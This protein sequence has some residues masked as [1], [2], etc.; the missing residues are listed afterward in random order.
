MRK[1][2]LLAAAAGLAVAGST[3]KADFVMSIG[4]GT[5]L[6]FN[7]QALVAYPITIVNNGMGNTAGTTKFLG[8]DLTL[9]AYAPGTLRTGSTLPNANGSLVIHAFDQTPGDGTAPPDDADFSGT[10]GQTPLLSYVRFGTNTQIPQWTLVSTTPALNS[11]DDAAA[12]APTPTNPTPYQDGQ[13]LHQFE[14][15][16]AFNLAGNG[17][18]DTTAH[19]IALAVVPVGDSIS[20]SGFAGAES[21][22]QVATEVDNLVP[23]PA[24]LGLLGVGL[25][26]LVMRRR[27]A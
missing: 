27:R 11:P 12:I 25:G 26:A 9:A 6:T 24:S 4:T 7:G 13:S 20:A 23:E 19:L 22:P 16:G 15:V 2:A 18:T 14:V 5:P 17:A 8:A 10:S 1:Y 3:A 21:G